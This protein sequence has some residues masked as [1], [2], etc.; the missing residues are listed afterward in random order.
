MYTIIFQKTDHKVTEIR[1]FP[2]KGLKIG[3]LRKVSELQSTER[4]SVKSGRQ[5]IHKT[6]SLTERWESN[7]HIS[8]NSEV[9]EYNK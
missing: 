5:H 7:K 9:E 3:F 1:E 4:H 6:R 2:S 8:I